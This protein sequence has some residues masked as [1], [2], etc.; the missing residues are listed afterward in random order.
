MKTIVNKILKN[1]F[2]YVLLII[3]VAS[4][5]FR[6]TNLPNRVIFDWDQENYTN[7]VVDVVKNG[8]FSLLGPRTTH[9]R[10]FYL[11]PYFT[12]LILPFY[13][14]SDLHPSAM[15]NFL[16]IYNIIFIGAA[17]FF[18]SKLFDFKFSVLFLGLWAINFTMIEYDVIPWWPVII[19]LGV[20]TTFYLLYQ[21]YQRKEW[22]WWLLLGINLGFFINM[23]FQ[24][25]FII[26]FSGVF[27]LTT[28][29]Q[30]KDWP[31]KNIMIGATS[32]AA[33]F[34]PL[35]IFDIRN[36]F[37]NTQLFFN[38]FFGDGNANVIKTKTEWI[39]VLTNFLQPFTVIKQN[40]VTL[41]FFVI[42]AALFIFLTIKTKN[43]FHKNF[44]IAS[45]I[46]WF[47]IPLFFI[48]YG[49]RPTE[50][51]FVFTLPFL[52]IG[53]VAFFK[54]LR[55]T[56]VL[57]GLTIFAA[58]ITYPSITDKMQSE[59]F[60]LAAKEKTAVYIKEHYD[61]KTFAVSFDMEPG[62]ESGFKYLMKYHGI[63]LHDDS[64]THLP[65]IEVQNP[66]DDD[67]VKLS[68]DIGLK[69]NPLVKKNGQ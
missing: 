47:S 42:I 64:N 54:H 51:Y 69:V 20:L 3:T 13:V 11:A 36:K 2:V 63:T 16:V 61:P 26:F 27:L 40:S 43:G 33:M 55:F 62:R 52:L 53:I 6:F 4:L 46:L 44:Y 59:P 28:F 31:W 67:S 68:F 32:F 21:I 23:H 24:F 41:I 9:D 19:P 37:L 8:N 58:I 38:F 66:P 10:G 65:L 56:Y 39:P 30:K 1:P 18:L 15:M 48:Y 35:F 5:Y 49:Q 50:Y 57:L 17:V 29:I 22:R 60:G 45:S 34:T 12:Y 14:I 25:I 7:Q